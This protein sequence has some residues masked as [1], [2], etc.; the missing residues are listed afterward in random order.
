MAIKNI[1]LYHYPATRSSRVYWLLHELYD[2]GFEV[3]VVE[4]YEG[5]Q[6]E[7]S[8][9][10]KNPNHNVPM[11]ELTMSEGQTEYVLESGAIIS[12]LADINPDRKL[13]PP[14]STFSAARA[15]FLQMLHFAASWWDMMLWQIRVHKHILPDTERCEKNVERYMKKIREE[16][17]PQILARLEQHNYACGPSFSAVDCVVGHNILWSRSYEL[18][19]HKIFGDYLSRVSKRPAFISAF[20]DAQKF[21]PVPPETAS[22]LGKFTG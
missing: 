4:L 8:Y 15:D 22:F 2:D 18:C 19:Q 20:S 5:A 6:Y 21:D 11:L 16:V 3:E 13:A 17:E 10:Q 12:L 9:L 1:K 14:P 7:D